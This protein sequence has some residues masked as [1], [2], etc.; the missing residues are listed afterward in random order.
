[1]ANTNHDITLRFILDEAAQQRVE[2]GVSTLAQELEQIGVSANDIKGAKF[3]DA[4]AE[5][6][7]KATKAT[8]EK[9][10]PALK[11]TQE[12]IKQAR[13]EARLLRAE[14]AAIV[15]GFEKVRLA[16][17][18]S[19]A[20]RIGGAA[21]TGLLASGALFGGILAEA[22][23]FAKEAEETGKATRSTRE[24]TAATQELA[25]ARSKVDLVLLREALPLL[26]K[27]AEIAKQAA[28][29]VEQNPEIVHA[30][31]ETGKVVAGLSILGTLVSKGITLYADTKALLLGSQELEAARLQEQ[32]AI[33]QLEAAQLQAG[34]LDTDG[35]TPKSGGLGLLNTIT[36]VIGGLA[37]SAAAVALVDQLLERSKFGPARQNAI[38]SARD[39]GARIY[40]GILP[41]NERNLQAQLNRAQSAGNTQEIERLRG[42]IDKLGNQASKTADDLSQAIT[43]LRGSEHEAD[44]VA[45]FE[46]WK[47]DDARIVAE[48]AE[49]RIKIVKD[50]ESRIAA[51]TT[52]FASRVT[53][54]NTAAD[55]RAAD[56]TSNFLR[57]NTE[58]ESQYQE[59]RAQMIEDGNQEIRDIQEAHQERLRQM[60]QDHN[61]RVEDLTSSRDALGLSKEQRRFNQ[62]RAEENRSTRLE[63][64]KRRA[65]L[66]ER[67]GDLARQNEAERAQRLAQYQQ[68]LADNEAQRKEQIKEAAAAFAEEQ[69]QIRAQRAQQLR[70]LQEGLNAERIRRRE[71]FIAQ[72]RDLDDSLL[73]ER[74]LRV[75]RYNEMLSD[76]DRFLADYRTRLAS[77][78]T[79]T[80]PTHDYTGY[81]YTGMYKM[82]DNGQPQ[83][84]LSGAATRAA[85]KIIGGR[86]TQEAVLGALVRGA[87]SRRSLTINDHSRF[88]G[89]ISSAQVRAIKQETIGE[90]ARE[91]G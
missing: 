79:A 8:K 28:S 47:E 84:V 90:I 38:D 87:G 24:W 5:E 56:L 4:I 68:A 85:E 37:A 17:L 21:R 63:I 67:L 70:E 49:Q 82:A 81:A 43:G 48:A 64:A 46:K 10:N 80:P 3:G 66:A 2:K 35:K 55:R 53:S 52:Q 7:D 29:F 83:W 18:K 26:Q 20:G 27:A 45:A 22:N 16:Q 14:A 76:V 74:S 65:D 44:I 54:I 30:A 88:D 1:M 15:D 13:S 75:Q 61:E 89:R 86:L 40:P 11:D 32:A 39:Q 31:L 42:E 69:R 51:A 19:T 9:L 36:L 91:L 50:A 57:A 62:E 78:G 25:A 73:G 41:P 77:L 12:Q 71:V 59:Q 34:I 33:K 58:A 23:R 72:I 60:T 6:V